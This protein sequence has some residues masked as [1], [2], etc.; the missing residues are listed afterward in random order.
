MLC[1][2]IVCQPKH[3]A[4]VCLFCYT[5]CFQASLLLIAAWKAKHES[6]YQVSARLRHGLA[7]HSL[8]LDSRQ[9]L[10]TASRMS[11]ANH[12]RGSSRATW[13]SLGLFE[14]GVV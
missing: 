3:K 5:R 13:H 9:Q 11:G 14:S 10:T 7:A 8:P 12:I 6:K 2:P 4:I 1:V